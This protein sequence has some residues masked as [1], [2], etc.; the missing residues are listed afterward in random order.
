M[1]TSLV[2]K[3]RGRVEV[4]LHIPDA[5][6]D[7]NI[8]EWLRPG[9]IISRA[10]QEAHDQGI[11]YDEPDGSLCSESQVIE[12][13]LR[14]SAG[15]VGQGADGEVD[16]LVVPT[17]LRIRN[18]LKVRDFSAGDLEKVERAHR[19]GSN[20]KWLRTVQ[21]AEN[22]GLI[23][24]G[25]AQELL[26]KFCQ[27]H[28]LS[29][30]RD[31]QGVSS[32]EIEARLR[33]AADKNDFRSVKVGR[34]MG[35]NG[36]KLENNGRISVWKDMPISPEVMSEVYPS[37]DSRGGMGR[38][39]IRVGGILLAGGMGFL[40]LRGCTPVSEDKPTEQP[41]E[42]PAAEEPGGE[43]PAAEEPGAEAPAAE[44]PG[45]APT[46]DP[47]NPYPIST[48]GFNLDAGGNIDDIIRD[49]ETFAPINSSDTQYLIEERLYQDYVPVWIDGGKVG[50]TYENAD[51]HFSKTH[52]YE[53]ILL[54]DGGWVIVARRKDNG[55]LMLPFDKNGIPYFSLI[56][57]NVNGIP[58]FGIENFELR[59]INIEGMEEYDQRIV[60]VTS[61]PAKGNFVIG[62]FDKGKLVG[63]LNLDSA[64]SFDEIKMIEVEEEKGG[65]LAVFVDDN[66]YSLVWD[67]EKE[68]YMIDISVL[69][70]GMM[71]I[72][73]QA[74]IVGGQVLKLQ[75]KEL[76]AIETPEWA[77]NIVDY[78]YHTDEETG[79][80]RL[81]AID[82]FGLAMATIDPVTKEFEKYVPKILIAGIRNFNNSIGA[83][84]W[85]DNYRNRDAEEIRDRYRKN[86]LY[87]EK[88]NLLSPG[89][90]R[91]ESLDEN[92][93][94]SFNVYG[95]LTEGWV[96][97]Y[98]VFYY[99]DIP[100]RYD[101]QVVEVVGSFEGSRFR[102][103]RLIPNSNMIPED[104]D[105]LE[106]LFGEG[107]YSEEINRELSDPS[108]IGQPLVL[109]FFFLYDEDFEENFTPLVNFRLK[110]CLE[111]KQACSLRKEQTFFYFAGAWLPEK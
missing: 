73:N 61:G 45:G 30:F 43:A 53:A 100:L 108:R 55:R 29:G 38:G 5:I 102:P 76:V 7:G 47:G 44:E 15:F 26:Q 88:G 69:G 82:D 52:T 48:E 95:Y 2:E 110:E 81:Y 51:D 10:K 87:D 33:A 1:A 97:D 107:E 89:V 19:L 99:L 92:G 17:V 68:E 16:V 86:P 23:T 25:K 105:K 49:I 83:E 98:G 67:P 50:E 85:A 12:Q 28:D 66:E 109:D 70:E 35:D 90:I 42:A 60:G 21:A 58:D 71:A 40:M 93:G 13:T 24:S 11:F 3:R 14:V 31:G 22:R 63:W 72:D 80:E 9:R 96:A 101:I 6:G 59:E 74:I 34:V 77:G 27:T 106:I 111:K 39:V 103:V 84:M 104:I 32:G 57:W 54:E 8:N 64:P 4:G 56:P 20:L 79:E 18:S 65:V 37:T 62:F 78:E 46:E 91:E 94:T 75:G 41:A 36:G